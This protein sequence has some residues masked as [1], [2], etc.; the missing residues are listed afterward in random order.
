MNVIDFF[1]YLAANDSTRELA[2][3]LAD[4]WVEYEL[5]CLTPAA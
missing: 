5:G 4:A 2:L 1:E 3:E